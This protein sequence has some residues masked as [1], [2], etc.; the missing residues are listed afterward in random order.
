M[1]AGEEAGQVWEQVSMVIPRHRPWGEV[2]PYACPGTG[3]AGQ[4]PVPCSSLSG[5]NTG[6]SKAPGV[7]WDE[8]V[9]GGE[10]E[11]GE[12]GTGGQRLR[13]LGQRDLG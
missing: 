7:G 12:D 13:G 6:V 2:P 11:D 3:L 4:T 10:V 9:G 1:A 8:G 5:D